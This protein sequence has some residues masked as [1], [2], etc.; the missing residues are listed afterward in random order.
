MH[1]CR[2]FC[3]MSICNADVTARWDATVFAICGYRRLI[4]GTFYLC[5]KDVLIHWISCCLYPGGKRQLVAWRVKA[6]CVPRR[7]WLTSGDVVVKVVLHIRVALKSNW[8]EICYCMLYV[9]GIP[10]W[11]SSC[12]MVSKIILC[13]T[14][15]LSFIWLFNLVSRN[16]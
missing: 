1:V 12:T 14:V 8:E 4:R 5:L 3:F 7:G 13:L 10:L 15:S 16:T 6:G 9:L 11:W 2:L